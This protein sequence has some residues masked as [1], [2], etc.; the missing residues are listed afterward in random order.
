ME[1]DCFVLYDTRDLSIVSIARNPFEDHALE[2]RSHKIK[3]KMLANVMKASGLDDEG[4]YLK[5]VSNL[6]KLGTARNIALAEILPVT[7]RPAEEDGV[8]QDLNYRSVFFKHFKTTFTQEESTIRMTIDLTD[9]D[10]SSQFSMSVTENNGPS[11]FYI[12]KYGSPGKLLSS[13]KVNINDFKN[14]K[15]I[16]IPKIIK[17]ERISIWAA[18]NY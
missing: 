10:L 9:P 4:D 8:V 15:E 17:D 18:R 12:S 1:T 5:F 7:E 11:T 6:W 2:H 14:K 13:H 3:T 16:T